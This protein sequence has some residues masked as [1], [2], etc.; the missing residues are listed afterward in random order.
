MTHNIEML[1]ERYTKLLDTLCREYN[2]ADCLDGNAPEDIAYNWEECERATKDLGIWTSAGATKF[3]IGDNNCDYIIKIQPPCVNS[4]DDYDYDDEDEDRHYEDF[5][6]CAREVE[7]YN[8]AVVEGYSD[9]FAWTAKLFDYDFSDWCT[10]SVYVMEWCKCDYNLIDDEMDEWHF[11]QYRTS[12]GLEDNDEVREQYYSRGRGDK[13][14]SERMLEWVYSVWGEEYDPSSDFIQFMRR[15]FINDIHSGN[16]GWHGNTI[17][18]TD[19]SGYGA[20][21]SR[22]SLHY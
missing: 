10:L 16:W 5:D 11:T 8:T 3:V 19:Y 4:E 14:Y 6:Y 12:R 13:G 22:R 21:F 9:R 17:V 2:F 1:R 18:L 7:V 15:M 20:S